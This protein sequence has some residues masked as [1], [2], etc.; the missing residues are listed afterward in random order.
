MGK[1]GSLHAQ[2]P[3]R[4]AKKHRPKRS[5]RWP[6]LCCDAMKKHMSDSMCSDALA[7]SKLAHGRDDGTARGPIADGQI[8]RKGDCCDDWW[9]ARWFVTGEGDLSRESVRLFL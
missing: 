1:D 6:Q 5:F 3:S 9:Q 2:M 8:W 7:G 4:L